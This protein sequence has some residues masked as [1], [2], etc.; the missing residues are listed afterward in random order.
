MVHVGMGAWPGRIVRV[1]LGI[2]T[3]ETFSRQA[4]P[5]R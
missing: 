2:S 1:G 4:T 3:V 5:I